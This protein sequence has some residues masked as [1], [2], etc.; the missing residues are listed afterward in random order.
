M[1]YGYEIVPELAERAR[2]NLRDYPYVFVE[3]G[4]GSEMDLP[5]ADVIY[6]SAGATGPMESWLNC[7]AP[8]GASYFPHDAR[9]RNGGHVADL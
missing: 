4:S 9:S 6:V 8:R 1:I 2:D 3:D 5:P 7:V